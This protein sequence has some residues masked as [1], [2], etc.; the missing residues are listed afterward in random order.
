MKTIEAMKSFELVRK[1][2][3]PEKVACLSKEEMQ[4]FRDAKFG[5]F[6]HWG[7]YSML[8]KGEWVLFYDRLNVKEYE[9]LADDFKAEKFD[10]C[11]WAKAAKDAGMKYMVLTTRHHDGFCLFDSKTSDFKAT[12]S[13]A[14]K[15]FVKEYVEACREA[16]LKVGFYYSPLDWRFPGY[17]FPDLYWENAQALKK[18]CHDQLIELMTNYGK[19]D[20]LWF[21][22]EWLA[23]G[24]TDWTGEKGW[25]RKPDWAVGEYMRVNYFWESEKIINEIRKLQPGIM[26]NNRFG[27]EGDFHTRERRIDEIRTDKPWDSCDCIAD[28]WGYIPGREVLS[29]RELIHNLVSIVVR[30]GNYLLNVGPTGDGNMEEEQ[31]KRLAELGAWMKQYGETLYGTRGGPV[32]PGS[33]GGTTYKENKVYVHI[34][35]WKSDKIRLQLTGNKL[36]SWKLW[37]VK[38]ADIQ[39]KDGYIQIEVPETE[40]DAYD[41]IIE[42]EFENPIQWEGVSCKENDVYGLADGLK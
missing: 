15:D 34:M 38:S 16:G 21:D 36:K 30:D 1:N 33:W 25:F 32:I 6:I 13:A 20:M 5:M 2:Y 41:T 35:E 3:Q 18:Q 31:V 28:S 11:A 24:G 9:K 4:W 17:F 7:I 40:R 8:G 10:A 27:W 26:I 39:E 23:L 42:L 29:L 22:G 12:N 19:I 14:E 37:N